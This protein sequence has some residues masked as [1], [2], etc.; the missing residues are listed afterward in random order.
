MHVLPPLA[1]VTAAGRA[2]LV[3][4]DLVQLWQAWFQRLP[5]PLREALAGRIFQTWNLIEVAMVELLEDRRKSLLDVG[6]VHDPAQVRIGFTAHV[7][8]DPE[9]VAVQ[10]RAL[11]RRGNMRKAVRRFDLENLED[12]HGGAVAARLEAGAIA[13][14]ESGGYGWTR[15]TDL[16][17][18]SAAL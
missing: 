11:V 9:R 16:S 14:Q 13:C 8:F 2:G 18:M 4:D 17:I 7:H 3:D 6:E 1:R 10:A 12:V 5:D 15:T